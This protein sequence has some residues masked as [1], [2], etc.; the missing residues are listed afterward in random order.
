MMPM[1]KV[2]YESRAQFQNKMCGMK[3]VMKLDYDSHDQIQTERGPVNKITCRIRC[4][5]L[6]RFL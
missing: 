5:I 4:G 6:P 1:M 2:T 3:K